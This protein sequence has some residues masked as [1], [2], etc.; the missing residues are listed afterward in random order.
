MQRN[1]ETQVESLVKLE[2]QNPPKRLSPVFDGSSHCGPDFPAKG[3]SPHL[4][5]LF[6]PRADLVLK[7]ADHHRTNSGNLSI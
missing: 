7:G 3:Y 2:I 6:T 1:T 5:G 4:K